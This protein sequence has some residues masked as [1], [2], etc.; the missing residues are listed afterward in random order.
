MDGSTC[1]RESSSLHECEQVFLGLLDFLLARFLGHLCGETD[2]LK[3]VDEHEEII[4]SVEFHVDLDRTQWIRHPR[5]NTQDRWNVS[6][7]TAS[8]AL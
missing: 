4:R 3:L 2:G 7:S 1:A 8:F 5:Q 6:S